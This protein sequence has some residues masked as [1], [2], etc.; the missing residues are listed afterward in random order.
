M[1]FKTNTVQ[2][3]SRKHITTEVHSKISMREES[4]LKITI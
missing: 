3:S 1:I 2:L 4:L